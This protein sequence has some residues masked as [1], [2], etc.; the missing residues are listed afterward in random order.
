ME[1]TGES[2]EALT[3]ALRPDAKLV[4]LAASPDAARGRTATE[5]A[6]PDAQAQPAQRLELAP[7][8][9]V[10]RAA[11]APRAEPQPTPAEKHAADILRQLRLELAIGRREA[12]LQLEP[13]ELGRIAVKLALDRG[14]LRAEVRAESSDTLAVLQR[15]VPELRAMLEARGVTPESFDFQ[16]GF[17]DD[18]RGG[19]E[20][21]GERRGSRSDASEST[22]LLRRAAREVRSLVRGV[23]GIDTYA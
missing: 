17:Q 14:K 4:E 12:A 3:T 20:Q 10:E 13:A 16:L 22:G 5:S 19:A 2:N 9:D 18:R 6:T 23:W 15:H 7:R 1:A 8:A 21:G 11:A